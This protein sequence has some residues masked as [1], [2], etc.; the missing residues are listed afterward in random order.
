MDEETLLS[1]FERS[2][3][4]AVTSCLSLHWTNDLLG[5]LCQIREILQPDGV[6]LGAML[7]GDTLFELRTSL[8]LAETERQGGFGI[9]VSPMTN[10]R[11]VSA[12]LSRSGYTLTTVDIDDI[13]VSY[14]S[15]FELIED[16]RDMGESN[17]VV[18]RRSLIS[19]DVLASASAIYHQLH[20]LEDGTVP[21][22]FQIIYMIGWRPAPGQAKP[23]EPGSASTK[24]KDV[25]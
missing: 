20:G 14:P 2:S 17:A 11:D 10:I 23:L 18:E 22:T 16:L 25:I 4:P 24:L 9:R 21:A 12:L 19:R 3:V 7:G 15:M 1:Y 6:F 13:T 8:Q 5:V